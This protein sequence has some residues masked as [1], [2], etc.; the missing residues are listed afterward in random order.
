MKNILL[1]DDNKKILELLSTM[2]PWKETGFQLAGLAADGR[3]ALE[4]AR[5]T[6]ID[7]LVTDMKMPVMD[8]LELI[9]HFRELYPH[10]KILVLSS[11]N[12]FNMV[13]E[14]F[15]LGSS[16]Y[17]LKTELDTD[18]FKKLL[19][20]VSEELDSDK[21]ERAFGK[22]S[23]EFSRKELFENRH[24]IK[25]ILLN[26]FVRGY[27]KDEDLLKKD[28]ISLDV[29]FV[30]G[31]CRV[32]QFSVDN[33]NSLMKNVWNGDEPF[34]SFAVLNI[35][36]E[37]FCN[38]YTADSFYTSS[39][40]FV[41]VCYAKG[42]DEI[43]GVDPFTQV[44]DHLK[45][46]LLAYLKVK[47]SAGIC[48]MPGETSCLKELYQS[49]CSACRSK[50]IYGQGKLLCD[51]NTFE[52]T[53]KKS[54]Q[55]AERVEY[56]RSALKSLNPDIL[57]NAHE[58]LCVEEGEVNVREY[59]EVVRLFEKYSIVIN[60]F[61]EV[62]GMMEVCGSYIHK[63]DEN[64]Y[65]TWSV[66]QLNRWL[67]DLLI[68][69]SRQFITYN[70]TV[71]RVILYVR[72][73]YFKDISLQFV[74]D[75]VGMNRSQLSRLIRKELWTTFPEYLNSIRLDKAKELMACNKYKLY[76]IAEKCGYSNFEHFSRI[77]KKMTGTTPKEWDRG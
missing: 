76:E 27:I 60:E 75:E 71:S 74:A 15:K 70:D 21:E 9:R 52:N 45:E 48:M 61:A 34:F 46:A 59:G 31:Y 24:Y 44:F 40:E 12:E 68:T 19:I 35:I 54:I 22:D 29:K 8:G 50:Y 13:R 30:K 36:D 1:V 63:F 25:G 47:I 66:K 3:E 62:N 57:R 14:A 28:L 6:N 55:I 56:L 32:M 20:Q 7:I 26:Q 73:N 11:Y 17:M 2:I 18:S 77:F 38:Y 16:E 4:I 51:V 43:S 5:A 72:D 53:P 23:T 64:N 39:G 49:A 10:A 42:M 69:I 67:K 41:V 65:D 37:V 58:I 33:F